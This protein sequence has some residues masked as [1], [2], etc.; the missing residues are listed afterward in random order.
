[1]LIS[2]FFSRCAAK[3]Q[4]VTEFNEFLSLKL[5]VGGNNRHNLY[6]MP[7]GVVVEKNFRGFMKALKIDSIEVSF[8]HLSF[9]CPT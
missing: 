4:I 8:V 6:G 5:L 9:N 3:L 1:M 7:T 2:S